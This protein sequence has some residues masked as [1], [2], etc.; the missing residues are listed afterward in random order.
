MSKMSF[1][2]SLEI[3]WVCLQIRPVLGAVA[4]RIN[5]R[6]NLI[7]SDSSRKEDPFQGLKLGFCLTLRNESSKETRVLMKQEILLGKGTWVESSRVY[8]SGKCSQ[9]KLKLQQFTY[10]SWTIQKAE[11]RRI[12]TFQ[13]HTGDSDEPQSIVSC[14]VLALRADTTGHSF[15]LKD[16]Y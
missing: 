8:T 1:R 16:H 7:L 11:H 3:P 6:G 2:V 15:W 9:K 10:L 13:L 12:D 14:E 4:F 5:A